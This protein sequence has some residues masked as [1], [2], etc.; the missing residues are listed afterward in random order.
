MI[1]YSLE[2]FVSNTYLEFIK[3]YLELEILNE[4]VVILFNK[5]KKLIKTLTF[6]LTVLGS[7]YCII[8]SKCV[9]D[10]ANF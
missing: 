5:I 3:Q 6:S 7:R 10:T 8:T 4:K 9:F 2:I 1:T